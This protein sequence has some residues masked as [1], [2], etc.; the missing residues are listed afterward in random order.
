MIR[1]SP[2][3][4]TP[5]YLDRVVCDIHP[6]YNRTMDNQNPEAMSI[7][8]SRSDGLVRL[9][10]DADVKAWKEIEWYECS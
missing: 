4:A 8:I 6:K 10:D 1:S 3:K 7:S 5:E 2:Q 9:D